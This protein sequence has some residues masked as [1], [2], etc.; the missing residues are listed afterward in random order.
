MRS[1]TEYQYCLQLKVNLQNLIW[2]GWYWSYT[3]QQVSQKKHFLVFFP[4]ISTNMKEMSQWLTP[5]M[6]QIIS[7]QSYW[8]NK[9]MFINAAMKKG[10]QGWSVQSYYITSTSFV[11]LVDCSNHTDIIKL[12]YNYDIFSWKIILHMWHVCTRT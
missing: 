11:N 8:K 7:L 12:R 5:Q 4:D 2:Q 9:N 1:S 10:F 3:F 6:W